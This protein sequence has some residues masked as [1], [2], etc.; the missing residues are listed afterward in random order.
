MSRWMF[1][2]FVAVALLL[3][4]CQTA[5]PSSPVVAVDSPSEQELKSKYLVS[6]EF[7][8]MEGFEID[9]YGRIPETTLIGADLDTEL[10]L[11]T[12]LKRFNELLVSDGWNISK[13]E[14]SKTSFRL[15]AFS[16]DEM[17]E[18]RAV[19][20]TGPTHVF[21]LYQPAPEEELK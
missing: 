8:F 4:G 10:D 2:W 12:I 3:S 20:G 13:A 14:V 15:V 6:P 17:V 19:Q 7:P 9:Q 11:K 5:V 21:V 18:I 1:L 16:E